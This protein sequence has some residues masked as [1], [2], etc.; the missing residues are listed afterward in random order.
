VK[1]PELFVLDTSA[2]MTFLE[3]EDGADRVE[4]VLREDVVFFPW[5]VLMEVAYISQQEHSPRMATY[6]LAA[7]KTMGATILWEMDEA[8]LSVAADWKANYRISFADAII[9]AYAFRQDAILLHKDPEFETLTGKFVLE[10]LPSK[11]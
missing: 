11:G 4:Q 1:T 3:D 8:T 10:A 9:A 2:M 7:M 6:R 5:T